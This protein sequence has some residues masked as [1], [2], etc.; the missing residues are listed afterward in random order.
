[1]HNTSR[2]IHPAPMRTITVFFVFV[3]ASS[4]VVTA[5]FLSCGNG[6]E[7]NCCD[8]HESCAEWARNNECENNPEWMLPNCQ[9]SCHSCETHTSQCGTG[10]ESN[11]CDQHPSCASWAQQ[12]ECQ[13]NPEWMLPN[14]PLSCHNCDSDEATTDP[15]N[16][17]SGGG[18]KREV[19]MISESAAVA[20]GRHH[21][22]ALFQS[23]NLWYGKSRQNGGYY[24][25]DFVGP[26]H[27]FTKQKLLCRSFTVCGTGKE[28]NC[29]DKHPSCASW[30][31][32]GECQNNPEW[33]LPNCQLS[34]HSC[35]TESDEPS[36]ETSMCGTGNES[37]CCD[38]HPNCAFW[39]R[40]RECKS[41][42]DWMLPNCPLSCRNCGTDF[43]KQTTK[44]RQCG[45]G[46]ESECCDHHSSCAFWAS[47]GECRKDPDWMLRKCQL[48]CHFCQT[49][50]DE[51]LPD[52]SR[53]NRIQGNIRG[54]GGDGRRGCPSSG[55]GQDV[56]RDAT[57]PHAYA[58]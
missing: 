33:M 18:W 42:P 14:C 38:K 16:K 34:C 57:A 31:Q 6:A 49:E 13:N 32:Q 7:S 25:F 37:N 23:V 43:D 19:S 3:A 54:E 35:E 53:V 8:K 52:P 24:E 11:C 15:S 5:E 30:A 39:A 22:H 29:C 36:T 44:V 21:S 26:V 28:S 1:M 56:R 10:R 27:M 41:N 12:G 17:I 46:K 45:T 55:G 20:D 4:S 58:H 9:L 48:S 50:E 40:R 2:T 51:P 47:K